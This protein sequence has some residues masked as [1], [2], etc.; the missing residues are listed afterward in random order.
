MLLLGGAMTAARAL[1]AAEGDAGVSAVPMLLPRPVCTVHARLPPGSAPVFGIIDLTYDSA[2]A[3]LARTRR[4]EP[5]SLLT[6][7]WRE[8][9]SN[10]QFREG[11]GWLSGERDLRWRRPG[12]KTRVATDFS[13]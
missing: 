1:C 11:T 5:S 13:T 2:T 6:R 8:L 12:T 4:S 7:R 10:F 9:D 3:C